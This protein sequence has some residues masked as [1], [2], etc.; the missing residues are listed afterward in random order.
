MRQPSYRLRIPESLVE[1][2]R[3]THPHLSRKIKA[4]LQ[5]IL[6]NPNEGKALKNDLEGLR[7]FRVSRFQIIYRIGKNIIEIIAVGPRERVYEETLRILRKE[8]RR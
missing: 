5:I 3:G 1:L 7:S 2:L 6:S 8:A 4:S